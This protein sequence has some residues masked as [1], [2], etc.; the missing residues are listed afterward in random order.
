MVEIAEGKVSCDGQPRVAQQDKIISMTRIATFIAITILIMQGCSPLADKNLEEPVARAFEKYLY[1]SDLGKVIPTGTNPE[2]STLLAK[3]YIER[4]VSDQL[5]EHRAKES[6]TEEQM[7]FDSQIEEYH[8]S[9]LIYTYRQKLLEQKMDTEVTERE[10]QAYYEENTKNFLLS[11]D[12]IKGTFI[13]VP[14]SAP[15][16][17]QLRRWSWNNREEDLDQLEKYC[18]S[19][20]EKFSDFNDTWVYFSSIKGQL[21]MRISD[22]S[23]YLQSYRNI[24]TSDSLYRYMVHI[25]DYLIEGEV[26]PVEMVTEDITNIILNKRKIEFINELEHQVYTD[27][28]TRNQFEIYRK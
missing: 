6:L 3:R 24:E 25:S 1:P 18:I 14:L 15:N 11:Q 7:D 19:Y 22:P 27:G 4:W 16:L 20:A 9:L 5:M 23:R 10:I 8:R 21:P 28:V 17:E 13:K 2:D 26:A 12:V